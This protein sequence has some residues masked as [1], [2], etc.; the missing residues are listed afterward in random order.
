MS[1]VIAFG[2]EHWDLCFFAV[3]SVIGVIWYRLDVRTPKRSYV[4]WGSKSRISDMRPDKLEA[5]LARD[6]GLAELIAEYLRRSDVAMPG[7]VWASMQEEPLVKSLYKKRIE[8]ADQYMRW[9]E[10]LGSD[11][12]SI[13]PADERAA[14][15]EEPLVKRPYNKRLESCRQRYGM[16]GWMDGWMDG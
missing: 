4:L 14:F 13:R 11:A 6:K 15:S 1:T 10:I 2:V 7:D 3:L 5:L 16:D 9:S 12:D 8:L